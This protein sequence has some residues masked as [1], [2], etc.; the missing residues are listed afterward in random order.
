MWGL[1]VQLALTLELQADGWSISMTTFLW[2]LA[3]TENT[4]LPARKPQC[5]I[6]ESVPRLKAAIEWAEITLALSVWPSLVTPHCS[7]PSP[8]Q[9]LSLPQWGL[10]LQLGSA[11]GY[12]NEPG[13]FSYA[14]SKGMSER[15][16]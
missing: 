12:T 15:R 2:D 5:H 1:A 6:P 10:E 7:H 16:A 3:K 9:P 8:P 13:P 4:P 11:A 14:Q